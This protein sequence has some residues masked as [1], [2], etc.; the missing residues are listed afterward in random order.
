MNALWLRLLNSTYRKEPVA[1]FA[2]T[3]GVVDAV[4]GSVGASGSLFCFGLATVGVA[5]VVRWWHQRSALEQAENPP[6]YY[7]PSRT[8]SGA[9]LPVLKQ[10]R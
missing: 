10:R 3:V 2:I 5:V 7:L 8:S 4:I 1:S 6:E 9:R